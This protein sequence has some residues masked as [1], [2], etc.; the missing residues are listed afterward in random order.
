[1]SAESL[2]LSSYQFCLKPGGQDGGHSGRGGGWEGGDYS[3]RA[4]SSGLRFILLKL[5]YYWLDMAM[6]RVKEDTEDFIE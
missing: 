1:M 5:S 3:D 6:Q 4:G 2:Q